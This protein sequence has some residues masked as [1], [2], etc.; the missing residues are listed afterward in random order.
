MTGCLVRLLVAATILTAALAVWLH[1]VDQ[2]A[3]TIA[4]LEEAA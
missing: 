4:M 2:L 1:N 3:P